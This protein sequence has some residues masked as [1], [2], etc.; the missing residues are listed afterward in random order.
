MRAPAFDGFYVSTN[1][2]ILIKKTVLDVPPKWSV[3]CF[4]EKKPLHSNFRKICTS[5]LSAI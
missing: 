5:F 2:L 1:F 3:D 4:Y